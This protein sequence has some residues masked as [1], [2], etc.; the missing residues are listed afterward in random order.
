MCNGNNVE[1]NVIYY[2]VSTKVRTLLILGEIAKFKRDTKST[3]FSSLQ[4]TSFTPPCSDAQ[5]RFA[6]SYGDHMV[7]QKSPAKAVLWG[8]APEGTHI[9][10]SLAGSSRQDA[11]AV[12]DGEG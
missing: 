3:S 12:A 6:S 8:Y 5:L 11:T 9:N 4:Q 1:S 7:L 2:I 10:V